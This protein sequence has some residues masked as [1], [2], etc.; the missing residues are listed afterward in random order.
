MS[1][2][3]KVC[4]AEQSIT[5]ITHYQ[6]SH[7]H[8]INIVTVHRT[9]CLETIVIY[10]MLIVTLHHSARIERVP[11]SEPAQSRQAQAAPYC[12]TALSC[13]IN[14]VMITK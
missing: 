4:Q 10:I 14:M 11:I 13:F 6:L 8:H 3:G 2:L 9:S 1:I 5:G 7:D 12:C